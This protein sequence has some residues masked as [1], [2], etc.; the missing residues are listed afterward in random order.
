MKIPRWA[1]ALV[2]VLGLGALAVWAVRMPSSPLKAAPFEPPK[3]FGFPP[4][5][6]ASVSFGVPDRPRSRP[7]SVPAASDVRKKTRFSA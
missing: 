6:V 2:V 7:K 1:V 3:L 4:A 5:S